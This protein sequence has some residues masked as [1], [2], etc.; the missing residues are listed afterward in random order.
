MNHDNEAD[1]ILG[2]NTSSHVGSVA[3]IDL[4]E[5]QTVYEESWLSSRSSASASGGATDRAACPS[6]ELYRPWSHTAALPTIFAKKRDLLGR[7]L[8]VVVGLG[9]GSFSG[10]RA[11][12]VAAKAL[13]LTREIP[14]YGVCCHD[15]IALR[16]QH[17]QEL[18]VVT[19]AGREMAAVTRYQ[20]GQRI[21]GPRL[22]AW[23]EVWEISREIPTY[24]SHPLQ[25]LPQID[26]APPRG[27]ETARTHL[28]M[29]SSGAPPLPL[30]PISLHEVSFRKF[31]FAS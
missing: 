3:W 22:A 7:T 25:R 20:Q 17:L 29:R 14:V 2:I 27:L 11:A 10:I 1:L 28:A 12:I 31:P 24:A 15:A 6:L 21:H 19:D 5:Q 8:R 13:E 16:M 30:E 26:V 18:C 4:F 9:P 23:Q